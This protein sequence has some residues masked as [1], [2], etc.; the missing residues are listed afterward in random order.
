MYISYTSNLIKQIKCNTSLDF[1]FTVPLEIWKNILYYFNDDSRFYIRLSLVTK[2]W[3]YYTALL[4][5]YIAINPSI[6]INCIYYLP[7]FLSCFESL[8]TL[9]LARTAIDNNFI[10][11]LS[12]LTNLQG[13]NICNCYNIT[14]QGILSLSNLTNITHITLSGSVL[15]YEGIPYLSTLTNI[16]TLSY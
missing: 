4:T 10:L 1:S 5:N 12:H 6:K 11:A 8:A 9:N 2:S 16:R 13:L 3:F 7:D 14:D 15:K